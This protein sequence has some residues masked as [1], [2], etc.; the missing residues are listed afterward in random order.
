M[1]RIDCQ[2]SKTLWTYLH[3][4]ERYY[5]GICGSGLQ[6]QQERGEH[7]TKNQ[8]Q[9]CKRIKLL[10]LQLC[11]DSVKSDIIETKLNPLPSSSL[12][13]SMECIVLVPEALKA[14]PRAWHWEGSKGWFVW[15][16][17][18]FLPRTAFDNLMKR[19]YG[20][21][22]RPITSILGSRLRFIVQDDILAMIRMVLT[23]REF[24]IM[25]LSD[26][27][28]KGVNFRS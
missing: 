7:D 26:D 5:L 23:V 3:L 20:M 13:Q 24:I 14:N 6:G 28:E 21:D 9:G 10:F 12:Y 15:T 27:D 4:E 16:M 18:T 11:I 25:N 22:Q 17:D 1:D 19:W 2:I 8:Y